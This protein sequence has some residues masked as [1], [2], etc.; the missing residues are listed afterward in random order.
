MA[1]R[2]R[3]APDGAHGTLAR[4][5]RRGRLAG[6]QR[7]VI[8]VWVTLRDHAV[9]QFDLAGPRIRI[10]RNPDNEVQIDSMNV[11]RF[12]CEL[13]R[14][15]GDGAFVVQDL[16]SNNGTF[17]NG[18]RIQRAEV[19]P[20]DVLSVG[21][22]QVSFQVQEGAAPAADAVEPCRDEARTLAELAAPLRGFLLLQNRPG[23]P[24]ALE[25]DVF[26]LGASPA[27]DL[28]VEGPPKAALIVRGHGGFQLV[29]VDP[30]APARVAGAPVA[31]R[32]WL[33]DGDELEVRGLRCSFHEGAPDG[34]E[35]T[36]LVDAPPWR[37]RP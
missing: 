13:V 5:Q 25:R 10:G 6:K 35:S 9:G 36:I 4:G 29:N 18:A 12:H 34:G 16:G 7:R 24:I 17:L 15:P 3:R 37:P 11:S 27:A 14:A 1:A 31:D 19:R 8:R 33:A 20:G 23:P 21:S 2:T 22:F 30:G 26:Q 32:A 28:A